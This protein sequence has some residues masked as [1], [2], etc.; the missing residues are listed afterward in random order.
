MPTSSIRISSPS[1]NPNSSFVSATM[2]PRRGRGVREP[3]V[4]P[5]REL[6]QPLE[7]TLADEVHRFLGVERQVVAG[8]RLAWSA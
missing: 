8:L 2:M 1:A 4:D 6:L 3:L 7:Q 5:E